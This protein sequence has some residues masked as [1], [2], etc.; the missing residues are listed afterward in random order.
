MVSKVE[1]LKTVLR[2]AL[3]GL[4]ATGSD[5]ATLWLLVS[6]LHLSPRAANVP[7]LLVGALVNF[8][9]NRRYA[10][11]ASAGSAAKQAAG[12]SAV[13]AVALAL[14]GLLYEAALRFFPSTAELYWLVRVVASCAV[15]LCWSYP[16]WRRVF[17]VPRET[18]FG[19]RSRSAP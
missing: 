2:S 13:E 1:K 16:L 9:G 15:F 19:S 10:F 18:T 12:Y 7:A 5:L 11:H 6:V 3:A 8:V 4:A 14:N 17:R